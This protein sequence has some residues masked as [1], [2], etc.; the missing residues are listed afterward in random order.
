M[1]KSNPSHSAIGISALVTLS[2]VCSDCPVVMADS[3]TTLPTIVQADPG[4]A[5]DTAPATTAPAT[6]PPALTPP[7]SDSGRPGT[8][9]SPGTGFGAAGG[10][11]RPR[12]RVGQR[13]QPP[14]SQKEIADAMKFMQ[15]HSPNRFAAIQSLPE[16]DEKSTVENLVTRSYLNWMRLETEDIELYKIVIKRVGLEDKIFGEVSQYQQA[17]PDHKD[18]IRA[19][20]KADLSDLLDVR[21][22]ER[23]LR[24]DRLEN[25]V[26]AEQRKLD[27]DKASKSR[28][29]DKRLESVLKGDAVDGAVDGDSLGGGD[30][31]EMAPK[32]QR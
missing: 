8:P 3:P 22:E 30:T 19:A 11:N 18:R 6:T 7:A 20:M 31:R 29:I 10:G 1:G 12:W 21:A 13:F 16:G 4:L 25:T 32:A 27:A 23:Q 26:K 28:L 15:S 24:I 14:L 2:V 9:I 17:A 5:S